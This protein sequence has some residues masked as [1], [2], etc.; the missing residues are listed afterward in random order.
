[1]KNRLIKI[2]ILFFETVLLYVI[3]NIN[4]GCFFRNIFGIRCPGCGLTR[5]F[6]SIF[7]LDFMSA[8]KYNIISIPLFIF[9]IIVNILIVYDIIFNKNKVYKFLNKLSN[10]YIVI[11]I[12]FIITMFI[13]NVNK[14]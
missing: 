2:S 11:L 7:N 12:I 5:A 10:Y 1:M 9:I 14:I 3:L 6:L 4:V 8:F 13:N